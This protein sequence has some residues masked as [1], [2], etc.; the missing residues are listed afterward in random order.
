M[1]DAPSVGRPESVRDAAQERGRL[2]DV[3][4]PSLQPLRQ[5]FP[6]EPL[7]DEIELL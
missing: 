5:V 4:R 7:H 3:E 1:N 2:H 6:L